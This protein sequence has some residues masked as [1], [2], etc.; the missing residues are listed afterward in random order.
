MPMTD[1]RFALGLF[2]GAFA[3]ILGILSISYMSGNDAISEEM[4]AALLGAVIGGIIS[5]I[6]TFLVQ[7][8]AIAERKLSEQ[9]KLNADNAAKVMRFY[10]G[11]SQMAASYGGLVR[12]IEAAFWDFG[13]HVEEPWQCVQAA[14][15]V[16]IPDRF[17]EVE[18]LAILYG[19]GEFELVGRLNLI[20][21]RIL[22]SL[23]AFQKFSDLRNELSDLIPANFMDGSL[24]TGA[25]PIENK[26]FMDKKEA[27]LNLL[28]YEIIEDLVFRT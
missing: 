4:T 21:N 23:H 9:D 12:H 27:V 17:F 3:V 6:V 8:Q 24:G 10:S 28:L 26:P 11:Y 19:I 16:P 1:G 22:V 20:Q 2:S 25:L 14:V 7:A 15:G 13:S 18:D 5:A